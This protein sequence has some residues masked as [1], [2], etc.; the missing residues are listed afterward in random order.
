[1]D[2]KFCPVIF[3]VNARAVVANDDQAAI[4]FNASFNPD[5]RLF[6]IVK[7]FLRQR[8]DGI[9]Q[10]IHENVDQFVPVGPDDLAWRNTSAQFALCP[11]IHRPESAARRSRH[12]GTSTG[13]PVPPPG[14]VNVRRSD[15]M[16]RTRLR[17]SSTSLRISSYSLRYSRRKLFAF[18]AQR[19]QAG[20]REIQRIV[21]FM[22]DARAHAPQ[23]REFFRL[24][25]LHFRFLDL[26]DGRRERLVLLRQVCAGNDAT[27]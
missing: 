24:H 3:G 15:T 18:V 7:F 19:E 6:A 10:Q 25:Q 23:R 2:Q 13:S 17:P 16:L 20:H 12:L 22:D 11:S 26:F 14:C 21:D 4:V 8:V 1:M 5:R 9:L 27:R